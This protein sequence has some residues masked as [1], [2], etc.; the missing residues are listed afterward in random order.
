MLHSQV[1]LHSQTLPPRRCQDMSTAAPQLLSNDAQPIPSA[2]LDPC[3]LLTSGFVSPPLQVAMRSYH[4]TAINLLLIFGLSIGCWFPALWGL[5]T[6]PQ[7]EAAMATM[8]GIGPRLYSNVVFWLTVG[9]AAPV[10]ALMSDFLRVAFER[11][12][13]PQDHQIFQA[14]WGLGEARG[15]GAQHACMLGRCIGSM[16]FQGAMDL[17]A[18]PITLRS[19]SCVML[20]RRLTNHFQTGCS[21]SGEMLG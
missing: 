9:L 5:S 15:A 16:L 3:A 12:F 14:S 13:H 2:L 4:L 7:L 6:I 1:E 18:G 8:V 11:Q 19:T 20:E 21:L 10:I 17:P